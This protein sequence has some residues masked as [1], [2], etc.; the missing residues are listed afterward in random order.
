MS[1]SS[2]LFAAVLFLGTC[3]PSWGQEKATQPPNKIPDGVYAVLRDGPQEKDVLPLKDGE[4]LVVNRY[5]FQKKGDQEPPR[6]LVVRAT[7]DVA[8][9]LAAAPKAVKEEDGVVRIL[10]KLRPPAAAALERLTTDHLGKQVAI[11]L[12]GEVATAHKVRDVIKGGDVQITNCAAGSAEF[13]LEQLKA[14]I[15]DK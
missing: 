11:V 15:K 5:R 6:F 4:V 1:R 13:L 14:H 9:A 8:L 10:L 12:G 7:P 2:F 3:A